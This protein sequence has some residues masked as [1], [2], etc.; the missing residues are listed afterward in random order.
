MKDYNISADDNPDM[1]GKRMIGVC[2]TAPWQNMLITSHTVPVQYYLLHKPEAYDKADYFY[3]LMDSYTYDIWMAQPS[4][5]DYVYRGHLTP[6]NVEYNKFDMICQQPPIRW[7]G[8]DNYHYVMRLK[9]Q[10]EVKEE[11]KEEVREEVREEVKEEVKE[12][13]KEKVKASNKSK[14]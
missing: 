13:V 5:K 8:Q 10:E 14:A 1:T 6:I 2:R 7:A 9:P 11:V 4:T 12:K 3:V